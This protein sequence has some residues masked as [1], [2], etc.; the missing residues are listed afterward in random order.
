M[1]WGDHHQSRGR[2]QLLHHLWLEFTSSTRTTSGRWCRSLRVHR[3]P[4]CVGFRRLRHLLLISSRRHHLCRSWN[5]VVI[6]SSSLIRRPVHLYC[7]RQLGSY[8]LLPTSPCVL[9]CLFSALERWRRS[10][11][12]RSFSRI[13]LQL[14][15]NDD[16]I[17]DWDFNCLNDTTV[18]SQIFMLYFFVFSFTRKYLWILFY[19]YFNYFTL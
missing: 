2:N 18:H 8:H 19:F 3:K 5:I 11:R 14:K 10:S 4:P 7:H 12:A 15:R 1:V 9:L 16:T 13:I 6:L 17:L